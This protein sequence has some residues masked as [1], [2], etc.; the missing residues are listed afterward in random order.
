[1]N[2]P[3]YWSFWQQPAA[4]NLRWQAEATDLARR[5]T[6]LI[7]HLNE[8][9]ILDYGCGQG[10]VAERLAPKVKAIDLWDSSETARK[11]AQE[12]CLS[13]PNVKVLTQ[14]HESPLYDLI[15]VSSVT[16]YMTENQ[17]QESM[18]LWRRMLKTKGL[19]LITDIIPPRRRIFREIF[20]LLRFAAR[21]GLLVRMLLE[22]I[23]GLPK[24]WHRSRQHALTH[25]SRKKIAELAL[26]TG[27]E[28]EPVANPNIFPSRYA[29]LMRL[30]RI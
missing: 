27:F 9:H 11:Q 19:V 8:Y 3:E 24:Y 15:L 16:Q 7:P 12:V 21:Y 13:H 17:L 23:C 29:V 22:G 25:Y 26:A 14:L 2:Q 28:L 5:L 10:L 18:G 6:V 4:D 30:K 1:M 20:A